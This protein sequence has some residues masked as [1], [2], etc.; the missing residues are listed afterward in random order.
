MRAHE[1]I[2]YE[3]RFD[4][5][6]AYIYEHLAEPLDL[7]KLAQVGGL[8]PRHWHRIYQS[9]FGESIAALVRRLRMERA[10]FM[11]ATTD[12]PIARI[13]REC[14][15]PNVASFSRAYKGAHGMPPAR[16]RAV[17]TH[18]SFNRA[19]AAFD[20]QAFEVEV[21]NVAPME[22]LSVLHRGSY[23]EINRAFAELGVWFAAH[24]YEPSQQRFTGVF[25]S[26][27]TV[28]PE[29]DLRSRACF[30]RPADLRGPVEPLA[31]GAASIEPY[32]I[33]GGTYAVLTHVGPYADM[34]AKYAW[35]C[36]CWVVES[37]R[38]LA[39]RPV[40]EQYIT[41][42]R[43]TSPADTVTEMWLPLQDA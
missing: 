14:G 25:H 8:S 35:L 2:D 4:V 37:G 41:L 9:A 16:F 43:H 17:G 11:L 33:A 36:G 39:D 21:R 13:A 10:S 23:I 5:V 29:A 34:P 27:P 31:D 30:E 38:A 12:S 42:P 18:A 32:T 22:S 40:V 24:G 6:L 7:I 15:Y 28:T 26:D 1:W 3:E 20:E 19:R